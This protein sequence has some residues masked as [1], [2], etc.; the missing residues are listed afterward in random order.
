MAEIIPLRA[1]RYSE[2]QLAHIDDLTSP[3]FDVVSDKQRQ[4]LYENPFNSIHLSVPQSDNHAR[5]AHDK[6]IEWKQKGIIKQD[7]LPG[8][9]PR[10][11]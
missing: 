8:M 4:K 3:L 2:D 1:W 11:T 5:D 6:V 7:A 9:P 10:V